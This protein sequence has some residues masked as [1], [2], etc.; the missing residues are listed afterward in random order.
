M[1]MIEYLKR[2]DGYAFE[3]L[4]IADTA[5]GFTEATYAEADHNVIAH[6]TLESGQIR[7]RYDG[8]NPTSAVGH[9]LNIGDEIYLEGYV[10]ISNSKAIR[11]GSVS[12]SMQVTYERA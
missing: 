6:G 4:T 12:G 3:T 5:V 7:Y 2:A 1:A 11:T 10:N 8:S 9:L